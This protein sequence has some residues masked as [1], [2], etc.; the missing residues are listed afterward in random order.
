MPEGIGLKGAIHHG[1]GEI[2][3]GRQAGEVASIGG[4]CTRLE[5]QQLGCPKRR[6]QT[7]ARKPWHQF[8][9][10]LKC[11]QELIGGPVRFLSVDDSLQQRTEQA[12][13]G[14]AGRR[15]GYARQPLEQ[16]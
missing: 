10:L 5:G 6:N 9:P 7:A 12:D 11:Y 13:G 15:L 14:D 1:T 2:G 3:I 8:P 16:T 4:I